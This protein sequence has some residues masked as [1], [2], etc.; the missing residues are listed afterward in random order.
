MPGREP[1]LVHRSSPSG[2]DTRASKSRPS[3]GV[4]LETYGGV[5]AGVA[6]DPTRFFRVGGRAAGFISI[7]RRTNILSPQLVLDGTAKPD[8]APALPFTQLVGQPD[9]RGFDSRVDHI[10]WVASLDYRWSMVRY[11]GPRL[12]V[13]VAEVGPDLGSAFKARPRVAAGFGLDL[14]SDST[15]IAQAMMSFS[16]EGVRVLLSFGVPTQFGD[17]QHR[18]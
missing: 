4:L 10:S 3:P 11:L 5:G 2:W 12:F 15:E 17:R 14:F 16:G 6:G 13:D 1:D 7:L 8:S 9:F 18:R